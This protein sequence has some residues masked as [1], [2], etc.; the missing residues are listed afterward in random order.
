MAEI[1]VGCGGCA[2]C[3]R[4]T[5]EDYIRILTE[6]IRCVRAR[7]D[8]AREIRTHIQDQAS[9]YEKQGMGREEALRK[10]VRDMGD[11]VSIGV[12]MDRIHRP[13]MDWKLL[14]MAALLGIGGLLVQYAAG[15]LGEGTEMLLRQTMYTGIGFA[16]MVGICFLDYSM[17]GK[18]AAWLYVLY[19][20]GILLVRFGMQETNGMCRGMMMPMYLF[21]PIYAGILYRNRGRGVV[22]LIKGTLLLLPPLLI[23]L[24]AIPSIVTALCLFM[25]CT[26]MLLTAVV[27][28]WFGTARKKMAGLLLSAGAVLP[29]A[30]GAFAYVFFLADYQ[31]MR[32][33]AFLTPWKYSGEAGYIYVA[34]RQLFGKWRWFG[35]IT[36]GAADV[37]TKDYVLARLITIYGMAVGM[38]IVCA[39][40]AFLV[41]V[42]LVALRQKN[43]LGLMIGMGSVL[44]FLVQTVLG[45]AVNF[46]ILPSTTVM[47]P[48]L[49]YGG[50]AT[51]VYSV[52]IGLLLS[53]YRNQNVLGDR[54]YKPGWRLVLRLER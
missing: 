51:A 26:G 45:L 54:Q 21:I 19:V 33:A 10:A 41:H 36:G 3:G 30:F 13:R 15:V 5:M 44:L 20:C 17:I 16:I 22:G 46:S 35:G 38:V 11:P 31:K 8:V 25:I 1:R 47:L 43:Q 37:V 27:K 2:V 24:Y 4:V 28:G 53:V 14:V 18:Y 23:A 48:F 29:A 12:E 42:L 39:L 50:T 32:I 9:F 49:T 34:L 40:A 7:E 52:F 6:Q